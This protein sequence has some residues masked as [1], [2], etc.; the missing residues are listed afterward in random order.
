MDQPRHFRMPSTC[1]LR[2]SYSEVKVW[3]TDPLNADTDGDKIND[4]DE[5][6]KKLNP[7]GEGSLLETIQK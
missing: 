2:K 5:V 6:R 1:G 4:G 7:K 3:K